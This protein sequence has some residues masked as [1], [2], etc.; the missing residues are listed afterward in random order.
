MVWAR[1]GISLKLKWTEHTAL[2][3]DA[4]GA[5]GPTTVASISVCCCVGGF[6]FYATLIMDAAG[7]S[8]D[9]PEI[10][11]NLYI[12]WSSACY[13][14][15]AGGGAAEQNSDVTGMCPA[16]ASLMISWCFII[17]RGIRGRAKNGRP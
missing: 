11:N 9:C 7:S 6:F 2:E 4:L 10:Q 1:N 17:N 8:Y 13:D 5:P 12:H 14:S 16:E 15:A 3:Q